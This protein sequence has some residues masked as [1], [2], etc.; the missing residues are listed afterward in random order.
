MGRIL[1]RVPFKSFNQK[2]RDI[3]IVLDLTKRFHLNLFLIKL[4]HDC[5]N[6]VFITVHLNSRLS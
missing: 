5:S 4:I 2:R 3:M 6:K 1:E